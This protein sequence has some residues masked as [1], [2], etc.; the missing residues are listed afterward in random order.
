MRATLQVAIAAGSGDNTFRQAVRHGAKVLQDA[1][2]I[3]D[4]AFWRR[5]GRLIAGED[6]MAIGVAGAQRERVRIPAE[7]ELS[8]FDE[9]TD[10]LRRL[11]D[12]RGRLVLVHVN[13]LET[14]SEENALQAAHLMQNAR[15]VSVV[16]RGHCLFVGTTGMAKAIFG[17][18]PQVN[19]I[20]GRET[21]L[22][23]LT[24]PQV[25]ELFR[26]RSHHLHLGDEIAPLTPPIDRDVGLRSTR[27]TVAISAF[28]MLASHAVQRPAIALLGVPLAEDD[29]IDLM[30]PPYTESLGTH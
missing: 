16:D 28:L 21:L 3:D 10:T 4:A 7:V 29:M 25:A 2:G 26:R 19:S 5:I 27:A 13:N 1:P 23:P 22:A 17:R 8:L 20:I 18:T 11:A 14:L 6:S 24:P 30:S 15:D 9:L 12:D